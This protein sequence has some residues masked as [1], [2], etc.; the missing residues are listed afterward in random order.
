[1]A[2]AKEA[3]SG[4]QN[5]LEGGEGFES[6]EVQKNGQACLVVSGNNEDIGIIK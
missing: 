5:F 1:M 4:K 6:S 3:T 2:R